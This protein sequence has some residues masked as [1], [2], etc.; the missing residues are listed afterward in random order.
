MNQLQI[1]PAGQSL[2]RYATGNSWLE[3]YRSQIGPTG[4]GFGEK[5]ED[6]VEFRS[7][8]P[9]YRFYFHTGEQF[10]YRPSVEDTNAEIR[11]FSPD[12]VAGYAKLLRTS[13]AIFEIGFEK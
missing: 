6:H 11:R 9:W 4:V 7:L 12:D 8:D 3:Q 13:K 5:R 2:I 1:L 10:D